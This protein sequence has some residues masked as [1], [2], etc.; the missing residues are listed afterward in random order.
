MESTASSGCFGNGSIHV[1]ANRIRHT[2]R[3]TSLLKMYF[4]QALDWAGE[5]GSVQS[6][7]F[8]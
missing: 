3:I 4:P 6:C 2:N 7:D 1:A 5:L 8:L